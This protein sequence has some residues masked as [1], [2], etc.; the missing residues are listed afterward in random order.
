MEFSELA[1]ERFSVLEYE[2]RSVA[3]EAVDQILAAG[4]AA[5]TACNFQ[6]QRILVIDDASSDGSGTGLH[7]GHVLGPG[8]DEAGILTSGACR[9]GGAAHRRSQGA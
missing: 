9:A 6:P 1:A 4:M 8:A 5:P 3:E 7:M 2:H